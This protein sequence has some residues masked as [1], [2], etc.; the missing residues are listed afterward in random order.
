MGAMSQKGF[1]LL[2]MLIASAIFFSFMT[3][4]ATLYSRGHKTYTR[5]QN[6]IEVQQ[7]A[8]VAMDSIATELRMAGYDP[9]GA[10][11]GVE[12]PTPLLLADEDTLEFLTDLDGD[13]VTDRVVYRL[14]DHGL[15]REVGSWN[16]SAF[17]VGESGVLADGVTALEF[18]YYD[19]TAPDGNE[20]GAPILGSDLAEIRRIVVTLEATVVNVGQRESFPLFMDVTL[21]N[22]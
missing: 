2:E 14:E 13:G 22:L 15:V 12:N 6:K 11:A 17:S 1:S 9:S 7:S 18:E 20:L 10:T 3:G 4:M 19:G 5:G 8:R 16:G 21:R